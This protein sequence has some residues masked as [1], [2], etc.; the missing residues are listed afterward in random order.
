MMNSEEADRSEIRPSSL[1]HAYPPPLKK[2]PFPLGGGK[3]PAVLSVLSSSL[4]AT[5]DPTDTPKASSSSLK[6]SETPR[7][8]PSSS[9]HHHHPPFRQ[10][11]THHPP[12]L[13]SKKMSRPKPLYPKTTSSSIPSKRLPSCHTRRSLYTTTKD[14][15]VEVH[16]HEDARDKVLMAIVQSLLEMDN[17]PST[18]RELTACIMKHGFA[19]LGG[20]TPHATVSSRI[21]THYKRCS[22]AEARVKSDRCCLAD[23]YLSTAIRKASK[24]YSY[25]ENSET[26]G[27]NSEDFKERGGAVSEYSEMEESEIE[28]EEDDDDVVEL[29]RRVLASDG[30]LLF[31]IGKLLYR[32][33]GLSRDVKS[34][35]PFDGESNSESQPGDGS[36][37]DDSSDSESSEDADGDGDEYHEAPEEYDE[38]MEDDE[39]EVVAE[40]SASPMEESSDESGS[41]APPS[42]VIIP[43]V[44][45]SQPTFAPTTSMAP[46]T[47]TSSISPFLPAHLIAS[48]WLSAVTSS[49]HRQPS[50][51]QPSPT[52]KPLN[53]FHSQTLTSRMLLPSPVLGASPRTLTGMSPTFIPSHLPASMYPLELEPPAINDPPAA[54]ARLVQLTFDRPGDPQHPERMSVGE[55]DQ[56]LTDAE[57]KD[58]LPPLDPSSLRRPSIGGGIKRK[59]AGT[60]TKDRP[61]VTLDVITTTVASSSSSSSNIDKKKRKL[62][63]GETTPL[64]VDVTMPNADPTTAALWKP[65]APL[66][67]PRSTSTT[68]QMWSLTRI[69]SAPVVTVTLRT[70]IV[71][72]TTQSSV[73][74]EIT[75]REGTSI[76]VDVRGF[77][78]AEEVLEVLGEV[79]ESGR[80]RGAFL[81]GCLSEI[82]RLVEGL[83][84]EKSPVDKDLKGEVKAEIERTAQTETVG[85]KAEDGS[86]EVNAAISLLGLVKAETGE[87]RGDSFALRIIADVTFANA[88]EEV[89]VVVLRG[90]GAV[91]GE[92]EGVWIPIEIARRIAGKHVSIPL[93]AS[94]FNM[95]IEKRSIPP[96][97]SLI[98]APPPTPPVPRIKRK[99]SDTVKLEQEGQGFLNL[100]SDGEEHEED[101]ADDVVSHPPASTASDVL[102]VLIDASK[103]RECT[104]TSPGSQTLEPTTPT[105]EGTPILRR[106]DNDMV[107]ATLLLHAGGTLN[108]SRKV[109]RLILGTSTRAESETREHV[110]WNLDSAC[111]CEEIARSLC[112]DAK[113][114]MFLEEGVGKA[115][116]G[117]DGGRRR[118]K[119]VGR[120]SSDAGV[121]GKEET[122]I[123][124]ALLPTLLA[125]KGEKKDTTGVDGVVDE[126]VKEARVK[127][128]LRLLRLKRRSGAAAPVA[129]TSTGKGYIKFYYSADTVKAAAPPPPLKPE[130]T[131]IAQAQAKISGSTSK[132]VEA[133]RPLMPPPARPPSASEIKNPP[134]PAVAAPSLSPVAPTAVPTAAATSVPP[135]RPVAPSTPTNPPTA[136][137]QISPTTASPLVTPN[138]PTQAALAAI[139]N[140]VKSANA[141]GTPIS[142]AILSA[143]VAALSTAALNAVKAANPHGT[144]ASSP[145]PASIIQALANSIRNGGLTGLPSPA[146]KGRTA[147]G[148]TAPVTGLTPAAMLDSQTATTVTGEASTNVPTASLTVDQKPSEQSMGPPSSSNLGFGLS[149]G[150]TSS[151]FSALGLSNLSSTSSMM[152]SGSSFSIAD[153]EVAPVVGDLANYSSHSTE[154]GTMELKDLLDP[155]PLQLLSSD[156]T[157]L[158]SPTQSHGITTTEQGNVFFDGGQIGHSKEGMDELQDDDE[159]M[160]EATVVPSKP[161]KPQTQSKPLS[162]GDDDGEEYDDDDSDVESAPL[163]RAGGKGAVRAPSVSESDDEDDDESGSQS[164]AEPVVYHGKGK[165]KGAFTNGGKVKPLSGK[166]QGSTAMTLV[167]S[168]SKSKKSSLATPSPRP[169]PIPTEKA[170]PISMTKLKSSK[171]STTKPKESM[172]TPLPV[173]PKPLK[174][175]SKTKVTPKVTRDEDDFEDLVDDLDAPEGG[176]GGEVEDDE[177]IDIEN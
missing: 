103:L 128:G 41:E 135:I 68:D 104:Y 106:V 9:C 117:V 27:E 22:L 88:R 165:G 56:L 129:S 67:E 95:Q 80:G 114:E 124:N 38:E 4:F 10:P 102:P 96:S 161:M 164:D 16:H 55:L 32:N 59:R 72:R 176:G 60:L 33:G 45:I 121:E 174:S 162:T 148:V 166:V 100:E 99:G 77:V 119:E 97:L 52:I 63:N 146:S 118:R 177:I 113:L 40:G 51:S 125:Q 14:Q 93:L 3:G 2:R 28:I 13:S 110:V 37:G 153:I 66:R 78:R 53:P 57:M 152:S 12:S 85:V 112:L 87:V 171:A 137:P 15:D 91:P 62:E 130:V 138:N 43:S 64:T 133:V 54:T 1:S 134:T 84:G 144:S 24:V 173:K 157:P 5:S 149:Q 150:S 147:A 170:T 70:A 46:S 20:L 169:P 69:R 142:P 34:R 108:R 168:V 89:V 105:D 47:T 92:C 6:K 23:D 21:S 115:L 145:T 159:V 156:S 82:R 163:Q 141:S 90:S 50:L 154:N 155:M 71:T 132:P 79:E 139:V 11:Q 74:S 116:F 58:G 111:S 76:G 120:K 151:D 140:R 36:S 167:K 107:N 122:V 29:Q 26:D 17:R 101:T 123:V 81:G 86:E 175:K 94:L 49:Q 35:S 65:A 30:G 31:Q 172:Y 48:P 42:S 127:L 136:R 61:V 25:K 158:V 73:V 126:F 18:P 143:A 160:E 39:E 19:H 7:P 98:P 8:R 75:G 44:H 131:N 83:R 109:H